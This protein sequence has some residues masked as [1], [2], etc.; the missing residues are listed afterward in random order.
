MVKKFIAE[1][2]RSDSKY[3]DFLIKILKASDKNFQE[4]DLYF[5]SDLYDEQDKESFENSIDESKLE[6]FIKGADI[7]MCFGSKALDYLTGVKTITKA[8]NSEFEFK[9]IK[10]IPNYS[11][12]LLMH[13]DSY[14]EVFVNNINKMF[15]NSEKEKTQFKVITT[16]KDFSEVYGFIQEV[17]VFCFDFETSGLEWHIE[18]NYPTLLSISFNAGFSY[19]IPLYHSE[20]PFN[21]IEI[22]FIF[23]HFQILI[24]DPNIVKVGH[25]L[26][27]DLLWMKR[28]ANFDKARGQCID[29]MLCAHLLD[30]TRPKG[31]KELVKIYHPEYSGYEIKDYNIELQQ[32]AQYAAI[33]SDMTY[34]LYVQFTQELLNDDEDSRLYIYLRN[35]SSPAV[36]LF[37]ETEF[38]G[39]LIDKNKIQDG[40]EFCEKV[41]EDLEHT[42]RNFKEIKIYEQHNFNRQ[43][44]KAKAKLLDNIS[45]AKGKKLENY[46]LKL[47]ELESNFKHE[48]LNFASTKQLGNFI[49][50]EE[51]LN[52]KEFYD[53]YEKKFT[54][55]TSK[56]ALQEI[57][58]P[59]V[60]E[61]AA[62]RT[63]SKMLSTYYK[64]ILEKTD[65]HNYLHTSFNLA[66]TVT[67]RLSSSEPNLQNIPVRTKSSNPNVQEVIFKI[68]EFFICPKE[69]LFVEYDYSQA[70]LRMIANFSKDETMIDSYL[71][72]LDIHSITAAK[73]L[74]LSL[75]EFNKL[76][77]EKIAKARTM[78]KGANFGLVYG[79]TVDTYIDYVKSNYG[80]NI[81]KKEGEDHKKAFFDTYKK[82]KLWHETYIAKAKKYGYVRTLFGR[83]RNL[84]NINSN[85][86]KLRSQDERYAINSPIQGSSGEWTIF[87]IILICKILDIK[88]VNTIH[89]AKYFYIL[90]DEFEK[91]DEIIKDLSTYPFLD[92]FFQIEKPEVLMKLDMNY[93]EENWRK[94]KA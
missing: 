92:D 31:L 87:A 4:A 16:L 91:S 13:N 70:E 80:I 86:P 46:N 33:D 49:Y 76:D 28:Y 36:S 34:R 29:T 53:S 94:T 17:G 22:K 26:K 44:E 37:V 68:K 63:V 90:K 3:F 88:F 77:K 78:A 61:L 23:G 1:N 43:K 65:D 81:S 21:K 39:M 54:R 69:Y 64:S 30:E 89:D 59:F 56:E 84:E 48:P 41:L 71:K 79:A 27:F 20:S 8:I 83:K 51:G 10:L 38:R 55:S 25:N 6:E 14:K 42:L 57:D 24:E 2:R 32:L 66:G 74:K 60:I 47:N 67:G 5:L 73:L 18:T 50:S 15:L 75:D 62:F 11:P 12:I 19:I 45:R 9:G 72:D 58:H 85:N 82:L 52:Q 35:I 7:L 40:I 93:S